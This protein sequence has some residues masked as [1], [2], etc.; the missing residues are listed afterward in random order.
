M[1]KDKSGTAL[2]NV[3]ELIASIHQLQQAHEKLQGDNAKLKE[4]HTKLA[5]ERD[6]VAEEGRMAERYHEDMKVLSGDRIC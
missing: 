2:V 6:T 5:R 1:V 3:E 4:E